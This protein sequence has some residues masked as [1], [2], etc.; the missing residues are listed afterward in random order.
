VDIR[1]AADPFNSSRRLKKKKGVKETSH[2][3]RRE[4]K[5]EKGKRTKQEGGINS[6]N[7]LSR[8]NTAHEIQGG[9]GKGSR[10]TQLL[11][12]FAANHDRSRGKKERKE[13]G[14]VGHQILFDRVFRECTRLAKNTIDQLLRE[15]GKTFSAP[16]GRKKSTSTVYFVEISLK[17]KKRNLGRAAG[18]PLQTLTCAHRGRRKPGDSKRYPLHSAERESHQFIRNS[19]RLEKKKKKKEN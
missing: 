12:S 3:N 11:C 17:Q 16:V 2:K 19:T 7:L 8:R 10:R 13:K 18:L 1:A 5:G 4:K 15:K 14:R 9:G 6:K